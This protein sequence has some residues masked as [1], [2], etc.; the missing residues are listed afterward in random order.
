MI[1]YVSLTIN[2]FGNNML[3]CLKE[4]NAINEKHLTQLR[5]QLNALITFGNDNYPRI[6]V[7]LKEFFNRAVMLDD[8]D[9]SQ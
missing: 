4:Y 2:S 7:T 6:M 5:I 1:Q 9:K 3:G 8:I